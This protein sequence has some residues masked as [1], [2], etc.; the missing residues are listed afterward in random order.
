MRHYIRPSLSAL[1]LLLALVIPSLLA[2]EAARSKPS[3]PAGKNPPGDAGRRASSTSEPD[4]AT[5][6]GVTQKYGRSL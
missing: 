2:V 4:A 6:A 5:A 3:S 1:C